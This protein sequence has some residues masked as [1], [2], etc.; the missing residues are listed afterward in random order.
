MPI[1]TS[2]K[3]YID[4]FRAEKSVEQLV[5]DTGLTFRAVTKYMKENPVQ[6]SVAKTAQSFSLPKPAEEKAV[7]STSLPFRGTDGVVVMNPNKPVV[8]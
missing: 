6:Q 8:Y 3:F 5:E 1:S 7:S 4:T 2:D